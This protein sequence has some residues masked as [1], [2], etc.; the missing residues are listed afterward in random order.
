MTTTAPAQLRK[1]TQTI[2]LQVEFWG[3]GETL[4]ETPGGA[5]WSSVS[6]IGCDV[7]SVKVTGSGPIEGVARHD[8]ILDYRGLDG[9]PDGWNVYDT[10]GGTEKW[11]PLFTGTHAE[12]CALIEARGG[13]IRRL[14][15]VRP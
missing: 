5:D 8:F 4:E 3:T 2:T 6:S 11:Q 7:Y 15:E 13:T 12:A 10:E 1:M 14:W 9:R